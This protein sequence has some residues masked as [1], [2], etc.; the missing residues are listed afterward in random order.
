MKY[1][2][3]RLGENSRKLILWHLRMGPKLVSEIVDLTGL[4]RPNVSNH[5]TRLRMKGI[6]L[7]TRLGSQVTYSLAGEE[8]ESIVDSFFQES[9]FTKVTGLGSDLTLQY[10][11]AATD[12][13]EEKCLQ[14]VDDLIALDVPLL[15][16]Y[17]DLLALAMSLV[18]RWY[19][20]GAIDEA[21]EHL[22]SNI[23]ERIMARIAHACRP[24]SPVNRLAILGCSQYSRHVIGI[25]MVHDYLRSAG[26]TS[27]YLGAQVPTPAYLSIVEAKR[28]DLVLVGVG[29]QVALHESVMLV[30]ALAHL[31]T[32]GPKFSLGLGGSVAMAQRSRF[33]GLGADFVA[34]DLRTFANDILPLLNAL[35]RK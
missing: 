15:A 35:N 31:R 17:Q 9:L 1:D 24:K 13:D 11:H 6:V 27:L 32:V 28:P 29:C 23:T 5:L 10:A 22:A 25:R 8:V 33:E 20:V 19:D 26:W 21:Q 12:G 18:G 16:L 14:V 30:G 4:K 34:P 3:Q 7:G 2:S